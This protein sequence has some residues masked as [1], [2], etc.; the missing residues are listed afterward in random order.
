MCCSHMII[1]CL[2]VREDYRAFV[3]EPWLVE[4]VIGAEVVCLF[5]LRREVLRANNAR[6]RIVLERHRDLSVYCCLTV[7]VLRQ[8]S[9]KT[10]RWNILS[11][12]RR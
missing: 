4:V 7:D 12:V 3:A 10:N 11:L 9:F 8:L 6:E 1:E 5:M 2:F